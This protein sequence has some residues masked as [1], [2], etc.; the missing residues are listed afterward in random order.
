MLKI[1]VIPRIYTYIL[2]AGMVIILFSHFANKNS[3]HLTEGLV[4]KKQGG[5]D[6]YDENEKDALFLAKKNASNIEFLKEKIVE[7]DKLRQEMDQIS[8]TV[9]SNSE[10]L[11]AAN[12]ERQEQGKKMDA[13]IDSPDDSS[14]L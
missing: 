13:A 9:K 4:A 1:P 7:V 14:L 11:N 2:L 8:Q 5:Y 10:Q 6:E 3:K 12:I